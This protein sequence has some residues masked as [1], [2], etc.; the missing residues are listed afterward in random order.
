MMFKKSW[1]TKIGV[2]AG[3][4]VV[5]AAASAQSNGPLGLSVRLG[6]FL[7]TGTVGENLG[8]TWFAGGL[9]YKINTVP[10]SAPT[11]YAGLPS[12][13]SISGDY[14]EKNGD[15]SIPVAVN[16]NMRVK[17]YVFSA[18]IGAEDTT[19]S[20]GN[21][22]IGLSGQVG[23]SYDFSSFTFPLFLQAKYFLSGKS[24]FRGVGVYVGARF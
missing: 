11:Q 21:S 22:T 3:L 14:Y 19:Y 6:V 13:L 4:A 18:G 10:V 9:D 5:T 17:G 2:V 1:M 15:R 23:A 7:P 24:E 8:H 20:G 16:Y 12:Y